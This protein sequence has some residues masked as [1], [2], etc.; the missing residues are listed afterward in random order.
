MK[1]HTQRQLAVELKRIFGNSIRW[2]DK[3][4]Y[5]KDAEVIR[6]H[7]KLILDEVLEKL[8]ILEDLNR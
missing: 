5:P 8:W 6:N 7:N 3:T 4:C 1:Q 2:T